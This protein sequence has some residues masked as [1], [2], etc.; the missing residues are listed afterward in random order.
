MIVLVHIYCTSYLSRHIH[1]FPHYYI[2][3]APPPTSYHTCHAILSHVISPM[4]YHRWATSCAISPVIYFWFHIYG[5]MCSCTDT[6]LLYH[7]MCHITCAIS[8]VVTS[9]WSMVVTYYIP[10][11][12]LI[13]CLSCY[14]SCVIFPV[15]YIWYHIYGALCACLASK[16]LS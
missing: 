8:P 9:L 5:A 6:K 7:N 16:I 1:H 14:I 4:P 15:T 3:H 10:V 11:L 2:S 12:L 13:Y